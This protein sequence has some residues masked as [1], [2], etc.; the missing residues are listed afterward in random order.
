[1]ICSNKL[2]AEVELILF[3][4]KFDILS[5]KLKAG[6]QFAKYVPSYGSKPNEVKHV[7]QCE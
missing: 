1:M 7:A 4:N 6:V 3:L 2:L 5:A